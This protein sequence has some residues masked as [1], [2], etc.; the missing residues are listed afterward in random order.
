M[1]L[2]E[3]VT[4]L[5]ACLTRCSDVLS[6]IRAQTTAHADSES[7]HGAGVVRLFVTAFVGGMSSCDCSALCTHSLTHS[8]TVLAALIDICWLLWHALV[9]VASLC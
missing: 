9:R 3:C 2:R 8:Q 1:M 4:E 7:E 6:L 5:A